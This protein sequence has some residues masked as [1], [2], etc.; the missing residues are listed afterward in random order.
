[1]S[2]IKQVTIRDLLRNFKSY[3]Q[4]LL[5]GSVHHVYVKVDGG[6]QLEISVKDRKG[7]TGTKVADFIRNRSKPIVI[8]RLDIDIYE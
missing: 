1:M 5:E 8:N 4:Q 7:M 3:K 6:E 2:T